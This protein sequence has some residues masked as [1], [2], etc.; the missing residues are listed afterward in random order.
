MACL[1]LGEVKLVLWQCRLRHHLR[2]QAQHLWCILGQALPAHANGFTA[3]AALD[4][5]RPVFQSVVQGLA[6]VLHRAA[7]ALHGGTQA[8]QSHLQAGRQQAVVV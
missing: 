2:K 4:R 1:R 6:W 8:G 7:G 3:C 5:C